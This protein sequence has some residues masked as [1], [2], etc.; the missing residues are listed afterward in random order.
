MQRADKG[1]HVFTKAV[2]R[3]GHSPHVTTILPGVAS[4]LSAVA[5]TAML[6]QG[7]KRTVLGEVVIVKMSETRW[8]EAERG[9]WK[10]KGKE[11]A[12]HARSGCMQKGKVS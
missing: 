4:G 12:T 3:Q 9:T 5:M 8:Q 7:E 1:T 10:R 6:C 2:R 11:R